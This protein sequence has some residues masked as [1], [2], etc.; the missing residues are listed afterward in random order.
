MLKKIKQKKA[1]LDYGNAIKELA[2]ANIFPGDLLMKNFGVTRHGRVVFYDYDEICFL[3]DCNF[4]SKPEPRSHE[5]EYSSETWFTVGEHDVFPE[6]FRAF[7]LPPGELRDIFLKYHEDLFSV[8][9]WKTMQHK[10]KTGQ[11][12]DFFP[13]KRRKERKEEGIIKLE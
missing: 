4:R 1:S 12:V 11:L 10:H 7:M 5:E 8:D 13:Y 2:A 9:F 6:E 3:T